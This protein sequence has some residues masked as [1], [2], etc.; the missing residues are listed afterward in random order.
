MIDLL[1]VKLNNEYEFI[2]SEVPEIDGTWLCSDILTGYNKGYSYQVTD[3]KV[4][5]IE[6]KQDYLINQKIYATIQLVCDYLN[7]YF[8]VQR[9][10]DSFDFDLERLAVREKRLLV[11]NIATYY[12]CIFNN[13]VISGININP[14][15]ADD[16]I[17]ITNS[18]RN[19]YISYVTEVDT[20]SITV[21][22]SDFKNTTEYA[23]ITLMD[24]PSIIQSIISEM[25][26][27]DVFFREKPSHLKSES[28][29]NY[30][31]S[32]A[33]VRIGD[34]YYPNEIVSGLQAYKKVKFI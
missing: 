32:K 15:K 19:N 1:S 9:Q 29:G 7:N 34:L 2:Q 31:Y 18:I 23:L 12:L 21:N 24:L 26:C 22:N 11:D 3:G 27:Y 10:R 14:F 20:N 8:E 4:E 13:N 6:S 16:L 17:S 25:V 30:S 33:D 28:I 5:R